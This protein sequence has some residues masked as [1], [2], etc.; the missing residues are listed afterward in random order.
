MDGYGIP[1]RLRAAL[2]H[3]PLCHAS[4]GARQQRACGTPI[5]KT[6][7]ERGSAFR[8]FALLFDGGR[9]RRVL[10]RRDASLGF[11]PWCGRVPFQN[12]FGHAVAV[13]QKAAKVPSLLPHVREI[14]VQR[15]AECRRAAPRRRI[16]VGLLA[17]C[18]RILDLP[19]ILRPKRNA[20]L[21]SC[22]S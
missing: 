4:R 8:S 19:H 1:P 20:V 14:Y 2:R 10:A 12:N 5:A 6:R 18:D 15:D 17:Q 21:R 7:K 9:P 3:G 22:R 11:S 16:Y 13:R